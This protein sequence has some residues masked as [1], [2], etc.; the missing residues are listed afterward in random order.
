MLAKTGIHHCGSSTNVY[1]HVNLVNQ[2][3][4]FETMKVACLEAASNLCHELFHMFVDVKIM[5]ALG[6]MYS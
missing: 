2:T 3:I 1:V 6:I 4:M 5:V